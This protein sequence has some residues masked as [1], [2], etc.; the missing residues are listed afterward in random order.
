LL[1]LAVWSV[2]V[3][4]CKLETVLGYDILR[5]A[6]DSKGNADCGG[7]GC[8]TV[9]VAAYKVPDHQNVAPLPIILPD[10]LSL[11]PSVEVVPIEQP[12]F[13]ACQSPP[14]IPQSWQFASRAAPS[15]RAPS[16]AS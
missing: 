7:D 15:P 14:E 4:H 12:P 6:E 10:L 9:E 16:L 5:C 1:V 13:V 8:E 11:C 3:V 2:A